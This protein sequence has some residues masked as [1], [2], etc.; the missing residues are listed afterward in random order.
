MKTKLIWLSLLASTYLFAWTNA[1]DVSNGSGKNFFPQIVSDGD[2]GAEGL[3]N[4][5]KDYN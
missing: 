3:T 2:G 5:K 4:P 1:L